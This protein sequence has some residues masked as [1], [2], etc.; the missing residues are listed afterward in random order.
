[1]ITSSDIEAIIVSMRDYFK[2]TKKPI[3]ISMSSHCQDIYTSYGLLRLCE[4]LDA[5]TSAYSQANPPVADI[6][7][8]PSPPIEVL[9]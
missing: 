7:P 1:M 9:P 3:E 8:G 5:F 6:P 2:A 4:S